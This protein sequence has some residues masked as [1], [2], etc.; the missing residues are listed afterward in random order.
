MVCEAAAG[1][2]L[3]PDPELT[4][5]LSA[6]EFVQPGH[7]AALSAGEW[8]AMARRSGRTLNLGDA[9]GAAAAGASDATVLTR[10]V[11]D[12]ALTPVRVESY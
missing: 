5:M 12:I 6:L 10:T 7:D 4:Q 11:R 9:L 2:R 1:A 8:R 3:H